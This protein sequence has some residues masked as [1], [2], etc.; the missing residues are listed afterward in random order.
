MRFSRGED[1]GGEVEEVLVMVRVGVE[2][3]RR[4][5]IVSVGY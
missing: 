2:S 3:L 1:A 5:W 4:V